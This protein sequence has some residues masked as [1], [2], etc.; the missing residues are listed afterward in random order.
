MPAHFTIGRRATASGPDG[1]LVV[2]DAARAVVD[3]SGVTRI[4]VVNHRCLTDGGQMLWD[5][6]VQINAEGHAGAS[7]ANGCGYTFNTDPVIA[8]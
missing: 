4:P 3:Q 2:L 5:D 1:E 6:G 7:C 8:N